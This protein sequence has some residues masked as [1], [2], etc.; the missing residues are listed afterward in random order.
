MK[1]VHFEMGE[2]KGI[3]LLVLK[4]PVCIIC[5]ENTCLKNGILL[6]AM[7]QSMNH[8]CRLGQ[9]RGDITHPQ[10]GAAQK[11]SLFQSSTLQSDIVVQASYIVSGATKVPSLNTSCCLGMYL[12]SL[13]VTDS[14]IQSTDFTHLAK[15]PATVTILPTS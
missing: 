4:G 2:V 10:S 9:F 1:I 7:K 11:Q 15:N 13:Q 6:D 12:K 14:L 8:N 3:S 5:N